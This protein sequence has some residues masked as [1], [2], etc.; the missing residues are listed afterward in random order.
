M[1]DQPTAA[2]PS[3]A[4]VRCV[5]TRIDNLEPRV[6]C[7][8]IEAPRVDLTHDNLERVF[9]LLEERE[10]HWRAAAASPDGRSSTYE[11]WSMAALI[12]ELPQGWEPAFNALNSLPARDSRVW[13]MP[14]AAK[15]LVERMLAAWELAESACRRRD[16]GDGVTDVEVRDAVDALRE[17][18]E[19]KWRLG[20]FVHCGDE[21]IMLARLLATTDPN[22]SGRYA[23]LAAE[24]GSR[25]ALAASPRMGAKQGR[26]LAGATPGLASRGQFPGDPE[27]RLG[28]TAFPTLASVLDGVDD[29]DGFDPE[30]M[31]LSGREDGRII[32][33]GPFEPIWTRA[34]R[35]G[36]Q[37]MMDGSSKPAKHPA[38]AVW[39]FRDGT[40]SGELFQD[41]FESC[42]RQ[43]KLLVG[44]ARDARTPSKFAAS[45]I[46]SAITAL[47][48]FA[49][50]LLQFV[51]LEGREAWPD[52]ALKEFHDDL[53]K[54]NKVG[55]PVRKLER[56]GDGI[57]GENW[58]APDLKLELRWLAKQ[59]NEFAHG[60]VSEG[61]P[62]TAT[63]EV[64]G[65]GGA[66]ARKWAA[67]LRT[68][69]ATAVDHAARSVECVETVVSDLRGAYAAR[70]GMPPA[71]P[72]D[73]PPGAPRAEIIRFADGPDGP[74]FVP[75][76]TLPASESM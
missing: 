25:L 19:L 14:R 6:D 53:A 35:T 45:A 56:V 63:R 17:A 3:L 65:I 42:L 5:V 38:F 34:A 52:P 75:G 51:V 76:F 64:S 29:A 23:R 7:S 60:A 30:P 49:N 36:V 10:R 31:F 74:V 67:T 46:V 40:W 44:Q 16:R 8:A 48:A 28:T 54:A 47:E 32:P 1:Q 13:E 12:L 62:L 61:K 26:E 41:E 50:Q 70:Y 57:V 18:I 72:P 71:E 22:V 33:M 39:T 4:T 27:C 37:Q 69:A 58:L 21:F 24:C 2:R 55:G 20:N 59:R 68:E 66:A 73:P 43:A 9:T 11:R 15:P